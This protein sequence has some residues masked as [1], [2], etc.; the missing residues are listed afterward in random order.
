[1]HIIEILELDKRFFIPENMGQCDRRQYLDMSKLVL[2]YQMAE[3]NLSQ[4]RSLGFYSLMNMKYEKNGSDIAELEKM[5]NV[6]TCSELLN[7]FFNIDDENRM[8]LIQDYTHNPIKNV[9]YKAMTFIGPKDQFQGMTYG[10]MEDGLGELNNFNKTGEF[11]SL[12]KLF[13]IFY[14]RPKERYKVI[15]MEKRI[16][17]FKFLDVR[18]VYG[19]YLLFVSF[20]NYLTTECQLLVD[21]KEIDLTLIFSK[22]TGVGENSI[23]EEHESLGLRST[24]F[25]LAE[26]GVFGT[27]E[28]LR[29][30][31][32]FEVLIRMYDLVVR[33]IS[34]QKQLDDLKNKNRSND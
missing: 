12:I 11:E 26:S 2:M 21:G 19:F 7:S 23:D 29:E 31:D 33:S 9:K 16:E 4:F 5:Q 6:Y 28:E 18:Y 15:N 8:H 30:S 10:E 25:Q 17:F 27:L 24:S 22:N 14:K 1:M 34:E 20:F 13:A 32:A 3:I